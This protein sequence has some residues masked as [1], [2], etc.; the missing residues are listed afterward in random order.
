MAATARER[1]AAHDPNATA[2]AV[3]RGPRLQCALWPRHARAADPPTD[4]TPARRAGHAAA[5]AA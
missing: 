4:S 5:R 2:V 1:C 3:S